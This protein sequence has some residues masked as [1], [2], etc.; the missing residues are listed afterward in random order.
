M[1]FLKST[2][3]NRPNKHR[4]IISEIANFCQKLFLTHPVLGKMGRRK[5]K[6]NIHYATKYTL[7]FSKSIVIFCK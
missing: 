6:A 3:Y 2:N 5:H 4:D 1:S 7:A